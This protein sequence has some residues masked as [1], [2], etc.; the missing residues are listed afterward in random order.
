MSERLK[1]VFTVLVCLVFVFFLY[2]YA[3]AWYRILR[4]ESFARQVMELMSK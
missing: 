4:L 2:T 1:C 3:E